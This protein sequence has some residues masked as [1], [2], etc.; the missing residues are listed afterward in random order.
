[1]E[2]LKQ[3]G[4]HGVR[5]TKGDGD[6]F[7]RC[8]YCVSLGT[9][10]WNS[11]ILLAFAFAWVERILRAQDRDLAVAAGMSTLHTT[12]L[13]LAEVGFDVEIVRIPHFHLLVGMGSHLKPTV[14][15]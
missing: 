7:Y 5:R 15:A 12:W 2:W 6:C 13:G 9:F 11:P 4:W 14:I 8:E 1:M 10:T 3:E